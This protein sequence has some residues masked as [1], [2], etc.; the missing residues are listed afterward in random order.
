[1]STQT[2]A[3]ENA[4]LAVEVE[5]LRLKALKVLYEKVIELA[6]TATDLKVVAESMSV[7]AWAGQPGRQERPGP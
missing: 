1:M 2:I 4:A 7:T 5:A 6:A 3:S